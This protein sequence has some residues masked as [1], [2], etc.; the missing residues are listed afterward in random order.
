M[1][2]CEALE[3]CSTT[4]S[5]FAWFIRVLTLALYGI[6]SFLV[7]FLAF[8]FIL[9]QIWGDQRVQ[10]ITQMNESLNNTIFYSLN[11]TLFYNFLN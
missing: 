6:S 11:N 1:G 3:C 9:Y 2:D 10:L 5:Y 7:L 8:W 4:F